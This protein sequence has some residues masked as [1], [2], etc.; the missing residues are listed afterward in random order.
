MVP[1]KRTAYLA[2]R[3]RGQ[4]IPLIALMIVVLIGMVGLSVDVGNTYAENRNAERAANAAAIAGMQRYLETGGADDAEVKRSVDA[5]IQENGFTPVPFDTAD[6]QPD[7][8]E[9]AAYYLRRTGE[10]VLCGDNGLVGTCPSGTN[11]AFY[12][13]IVTRGQVDTYFARA[14]GQEHLPVNSQ[15][16]AGQCP[17]INGMLPITVKHNLVT[18]NAGESALSMPM[19]MR[20][21]P[22]SA[23]RSITS[24]SI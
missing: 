18:V 24:A 16:Y 3:S 14:L 20:P 6:L 15:A 22:I 21:F 8:L 1:K 10:N 13:R 19:A 9:V 23:G 17:P 2:Q 4:S 12:I 11:A 7:E 5:A